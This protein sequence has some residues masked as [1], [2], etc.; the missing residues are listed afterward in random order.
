MR[1]AVGASPSELTKFR[2]PMVRLP[3]NSSSCVAVDTL[4]PA[5][6][7]V[8][9]A[10]LMAMVLSTAADDEFSSL[11]TTRMLPLEASLLA[12]KVR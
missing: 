4:P 11:A 8:F 2:P 7:G 3:E 6:G 1:T 9:C 10:M 12:L 5:A